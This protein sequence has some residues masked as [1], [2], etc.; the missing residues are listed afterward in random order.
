MG[1]LSRLVRKAQASYTMED[2]DRSV[3]GRMRGGTATGISVSEDTAMR[4][5]T[6]FSCVRVLAEGVGALPLHVYK[7]RP[8]GKGKDMATDHPLY[9]LLH[10]VPNNEMTSQSWRESQ[11]GQLASSGNCYNVI[12]LSQRGQVS[13]IYPVPWYDCRPVRNKTTE[14]LEY[15]LNDR[16]K[17]ETLPAERI[18]HVPGFGFDGIQGYSPIRM[19]AEAVGMG[20]AASDFTSRFYSNGMNIGSV[21]EYPSAMSDETYERLKAWI[22]ETGP[23][24]ANA[25]KPLILEEG[26]KFARI[27]LTFVDAQFIETRKLNRDEL[28]GLFRVPPHMISNLERSTNNNIEHQ[29]IEFVVHTLMPY[30]TRIEAACNRRLFTPAERE[31]GYYVKFNVAGLLRGDYASRQAGL[32]TQRQNGIINADEWRELEDMNPIDDGTEAGTA[33][34]VNGSMTSIQTAVNNAKGGEKTT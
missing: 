24:L 1:I 5:I 29:G 31:V 9:E 13:E 22:D 19:A 23:G 6:V 28:C 12:S 10:N 17:V 7:R 16:G 21:L 20:M 32:S 18:L 34:V 26:G 30:L 3:F 27:P 11:V 33:Y 14:L 8:G 4:F 15:E 2:F 25:W